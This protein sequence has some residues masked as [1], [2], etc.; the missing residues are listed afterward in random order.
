L[1]ITPPFPNASPETY[2]RR[3]KAT[4]A[5]AAALALIV[6]RLRPFRVEVRG[7]SM[8]PTLHPGDWAI[9]TAGGRLKK[10]DV[11]VL[12][13]PGRPGMEMVKRITGAPGEAEL[14]FG[15][16][17]VSGDNP[18]ASTDSR[19]FGPVER[20]LIRGRVRLV[21]WPPGRWRVL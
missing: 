18:D 15:E 10:G 14:G 20:T 11:I 6:L 19:T 16:W 1:S 2:H 5:A 9:A 12:E 17:R 8:R 3:R 4:F 21:Y 13:G 7:D